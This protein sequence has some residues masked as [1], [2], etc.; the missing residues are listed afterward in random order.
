MKEAGKGEL[1]IRTVFPS[2]GEHSYRKL[3]ELGHGPKF[4]V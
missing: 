1:R 4:P 2:S 3:T